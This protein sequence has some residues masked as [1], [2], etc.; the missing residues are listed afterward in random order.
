VSTDDEY[1][2][3]ADIQ[4]LLKVSRSRSYEVMRQ[5]PRIKFGQT[6]RVARRELEL[7]TQKHGLPGRAARNARP[8][9]PVDRR[10]TAQAAAY[11]RKQ[12]VRAARAATH[13]AHDRK[14]GSTIRLTR[15]PT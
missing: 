8:P 14:P 5:M 13:A 2:S 15:R 6:V 1:L 7:W 3:A 10:I 12:A 9:E 4:R 11:H